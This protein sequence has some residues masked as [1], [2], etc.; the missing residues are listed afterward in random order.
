MQSPVKKELPDFLKPQNHWMIGDYLP[1]ITI[2]PESSLK[3]YD[4]IDRYLIVAVVSTTCAPCLEAMEILNEFIESFP[5]YRLVIL[6]ETD[7]ETFERAKEAFHETALLYHVPDR[8]LVEE[9]KIFGYPWS[10]GINIEGQIIA[11]A[12]CGV[13]RLFM[14]VVEPFHRFHREIR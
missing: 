11:H 9:L 6:I 2:D 3:L 1:N 5:G 8:V 14:N 4:L 10:Y 13:R 7:D 12:T